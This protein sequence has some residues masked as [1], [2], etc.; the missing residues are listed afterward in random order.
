[1][2]KYPGCSHKVTVVVDASE[3]DSKAG[4]NSDSMIRWR[5]WQTGY[6]ENQKGNNDEGSYAAR[7]FA[8]VRSGDK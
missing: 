2:P 5:R 6:H 3:R 8:R 4:M 1:M 7:G